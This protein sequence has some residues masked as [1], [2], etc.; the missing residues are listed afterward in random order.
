M[1]EQES[2]K[3][4]EISRKLSEI[5]DLLCGNR[6]DKDDKGLVGDVNDHERRISRLEKAF[7]AGKWLFIGMGVS[8]GIG[9]ASLIKWL[10]EHL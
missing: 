2:I 8:S 3:L 6:L 5:Y 7:S 1:S 10:A 4:M 9:I